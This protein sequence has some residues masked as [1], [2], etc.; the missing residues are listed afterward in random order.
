MMKKVI[1][2]YGNTHVIIINKEDLKIYKLKEGDIVDI[3]DLI[4]VEK[5]RK[6]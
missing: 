2:K 4:K 1:K 5:E 3:G 6:R